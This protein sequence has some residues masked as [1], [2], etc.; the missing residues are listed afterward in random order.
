MRTTLLSLI[1]AVLFIQT[2]KAQYEPLV[3][4]S[5]YNSDVIAN[6]VG[7]AMSST[8]IAVDNAEFAFMT[9]DYQ[10][11][12]QTPPAYAFPIS[13]LINSNAT[14]G[15]S[16]QLADYS[17]NNSL[18]IANS[19]ES[20]TLNFDN[21]P[22]ATKLFLLATSGS[23]ASTISGVITFDDN[24]TQNI[25]ST[26]VPDWYNSS[27]LPVAAWGF[28]RVNRTNDVMENPTNNPRLYQWQISIL[29]ENQLKHITSVQLTKTSTAEGVLNI[30]GASVEL[31]GECP[32]PNSL[33]ANLSSTT[34]VTISWNAP[35]IVPNGYEYV[36]SSTLGTPSGS[37]TFTTETSATDNTLSENS[38]YYVYVRSVCA[39][40]QFSSW[41]GPITIHT[42]LGD[43]CSLVI[44]LDNETSPYSSTT[45]GL[46]NDIV[47]PCMT[48]ATAP[49]MFFSLT[50]P[51]NY[52]LSIGQTVNSYD[53]GNLVVYGDCPGSGGTYTQLSCFDDSDYTV[54]NWTN[55]TGS[56]QTVY[57]I[58]DGYSSGNG[59][60][61]L[62]WTLTAP[63]A[64]IAPLSPAVTNIT[65]TS[66]SFGWTA[67]NPNPPADGYE[68]VVSTENTT[69]TEA[70]IITSDV[71]AIATDLTPNTTYYIFIRSKCADDL[72]SDW[73][74]ISAYTGYCQV[75]ST[76]TGHGISNFTTTGGFEN[77]NNT[78]TA[79]TYTD[80]TAQAVSFYAG[81]SVNFSVTTISGSHGVKIWID[82]NNNLSFDDA[83]EL[84]Y[85]SGGYVT[86]PLGSIAIPTGTAN[87]D[88]R[89]RVV[90]NYLSSSPT[91]CGNLGN[92][93]NGEAEDYTFTVTDPPLCPP[94]LSITAAVTGT[95]VTLNWTELS[96]PA[97]GYEYVISTTNT[98]PSESG[99]SVTGLT[100]T[101]DNLTPETTYYAFIRAICED[102]N[103]T[104]DWISTSFWVGYCVVNSTN[105]NYGI[106]NVTTTGGYTN[107]SNPSGAGTYSNYTTQNVS[108]NPGGTI[109]FA[110]STITGSHGVRIWIDWNNNLSFEDA[111]ELVYNSGGYVTNP[112]GTITVPDGVVNGSYRM[113][114]VANYLS[115]TPTACGNLG[116][117]GYGEAEDYTFIVSDPP[118]C[119]APIT[120]TASAS[121][122][123][124]TLT[125]TDNNTPSNGYEY[126]LSTTNTLPTDAGT[127]VSELT[128]TITDLIPGTT[129]YAFVRAN[130]GDNYSTWINAQVYIGYCQVTSTSTN[131]GISNFTTTNGF[132]NI[133]NAT[134]PGSYN[135]YTALSVSQYAGGSIGFSI[136]SASGSAGMGI[137][138]DWNNDYDFSDA[139]EQMYLSGSYLTATTGTFTVP[140]GTPLGSY[141]MR[142]VANY[143]STSPTPCGNLGNAAYGE[144]E[145]YTFI[146]AAP[147]AC[148]PILSLT[149]SVSG[150]SVTLDWTE[151]I[152]PANGYEYV[153]S[154]VNE[155]PTGSGTSVTGL[156]VTVDD[157]DI[158]STYYAFVRANCGDEDGVSTW[159][160]VSF[161]IGYCEVT[162]TSTSYGISNF[163]T[164]GG[165]LNINNSTGPGSYNNYTQFIV[166]QYPGGE[167]G[168]S[169]TSANGSAGMGV[170]VDWNND[171]DFSDAGEQMYLSGTYLT[172][173]TSTF[174]VPAD[175]P[176]GSYRMRI[177][178][179]YLSTSPNPCGNLG[180]ASYGEAEDYTL[181]V[182]ETPACIPPASLTA[183]ATSITTA[184]VSWV[185]L[186]ET[187]DFEY[188]VSNTIGTP[189]VDGTPI[190]GTTV[191]LDNL[192]FGTYYVYVR[193]NCGDDG[194]SV[195]AGPATFIIMQG[196]EPCTAFELDVN[197]FCDFETYSNVGA[198]NSANP[199]IPAPGCASYSGGDIWFVVEVPANG[200]IILDAIQGDITDAG[201]AVYSGSS[202]DGALT[203]LACNDD[204]SDNGLMPKIELDNIDPV[205]TPVL[206]VRFWEYGNNV[207]G[208]FGICASTPCTAPGNPTVTPSGNTATATW[209]SAG[210]G[211]VYNWEIRISGEPGSGT[212]GL[213]QS[214]TTDV[215]VTTVVITDLDYATTYQFYVST[216]CGEG[217][218]SPWSNAATFTTEVMQGCTDPA[219]C[220]YN[221]EAMV[222]DNSCIYQ[223]TTLF[224]D[225]DNDGYGD[226]NSPIENCGDTLEGYVADST[227]CDDSDSTVWRSELF[228][229]DSDGDGYNVGQETVCYGDSIPDGYSSTTNGF[230][231]SDDDSESWEPTPTNVTLNL[232]VTTLCDG[233]AA[234]TL[235]GG[236][237][238]G[239]VW[240]GQGVSGSQ[241]NPQGLPAPATYTITY[242][243]AGDGICDLGGSAT[244]ELT[245]DDCTGITETESN[246]IHLYPTYTNSTVT[247]TGAGLYEATI[248]DSHGR[249]LNTVSLRNSQIVDM[250]SYASGIYFVHIQ[251]DNNSKIFKVVKVN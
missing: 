182:V 136:T 242:T 46:T 244:A 74:M 78:S 173:T 54:V 103:G 76:N 3:V 124:V 12:S 11:G 17:A 7:T 114:I 25:S 47:L 206:Y 4:S 235:T 172:S 204:G 246:S 8:S 243:V 153:I 129:Y 10:P 160:S 208:T 249:K 195:W 197:G 39:D 99:T 71:S 170:W 26:Q 152:T 202:C 44:N 2:S 158:D 212:D 106:S 115:G 97:N 109:N 121:G 250:Q 161:H 183:T 234:I 75:T 61:T 50:V 27:A 42:T 135:D 43:N 80:Y 137:W 62:S 213:V 6:G 131:Y 73:V 64:C 140:V 117:Q 215:D 190:N 32:Y 132:T 180:N 14:T 85:N 113:R 216:N 245:I 168:F 227:D 176:L 59:A 118:A 101:V 165:Y 240:S 128:A 184:T 22:E 239:G 199:N 251:S 247:V 16:F 193:A 141:R 119:T 79:G 163:T 205:A 138:V 143:L 224:A 5:G 166:S 189:T 53:S 33:T 225:T 86:N 107:I 210:A 28:G 171:M 20:G 81:G 145:D 108:I 211:S 120:L 29:P 68:Y 226:L 84:V 218:S 191:D 89:M 58:Q 36:I 232:P 146:V 222:D 174:T 49:D 203:L 102:A 130:C 51:A 164:T 236:S 177:V 110:I 48:T 151:L 149:A 157:L 238:A 248:M 91:P 228:Y 57:W 209:S 30:F 133:S 77:I 98:T 148:P 221:S 1:L 82:W 63:P 9:Q 21:A 70:G 154:T 196:D 127:P 144:A 87:G 186:N 45:T 13:G 233:S 60:F 139:G 167:I 100:V 175:A 34:S 72:Y 23:G 88:Y 31:L 181:Q 134:G 201:M 230:D 38:T 237:P 65:T 56:D 187:N 37:G 220:N 94:A 207:F 150:T 105:T 104:S 147:P 156:T 95:S 41:V 112:T 24:T 231:C 192:T 125:W 178:A 96:T 126:V 66:L 200:H 155:L 229:I 40:D 18:R 123:T 223:T 214:G 55:L 122:T 169:I 19:N 83:G 159:V 185:S 241:F 219:A 69:P 90:A 217:V 92:A 35:A 67:P 194:Y 142:V 179:N 15:L 52:S 188:Y 93:A 162:S 198:T 116:S 111:G